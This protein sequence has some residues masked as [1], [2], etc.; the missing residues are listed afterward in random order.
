MLRIFCFFFPSIFTNPTIRNRFLLVICFR[1]VCKLFRGIPSIID[2]A[3]PSAIKLRRHKAK[4]WTGFS[5]VFRFHC[6]DAVRV[7]VVGTQDSGTDNSLACAS[8]N[9]LW[10]CYCDLIFLDFI[11]ITNFWF[12]RT[13]ISDS[14]SISMHVAGGWLCPLEQVIVWFEKLLFSCTGTMKTWGFLY[15]FMTVS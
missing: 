4:P 6:F 14:F 8:T 2:F 3:F 1:T 15:F 7:F 13:L 12:Y 9:T 11:F 10:L 5:I